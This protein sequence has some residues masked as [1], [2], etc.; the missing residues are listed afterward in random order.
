MSKAARHFLFPVKLHAT[1]CFQ[2]K[3]LSSQGQGACGLGEG[4]RVHL[5]RAAELHQTAPHHWTELEQNCESGSSVGVQT[6]AGGGGGYLLLL[7]VLTFD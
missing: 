4:L 5:D 1:S 7:N 3:V 6:S 2:S